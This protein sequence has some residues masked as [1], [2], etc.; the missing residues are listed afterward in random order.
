MFAYQQFIDLSRSTNSDDRGK[1]AHMAAL[2]F[3]AETGTT[4]EQAAVYAALLSFLDD[5]SVKVR[6]ALAYG[7]LR[8]KRAPRPVMLS[9]LQDAPII[10]RAVAQYCPVLV[11]ADLLGVART[12]EEAMLK[13][14]ALRDELSPRVAHELLMRDIKAISLNVLGRHDVLIGAETLVTIAE[15]SGG[16]PKMRGALL[17]REDLPA[18]VRL[19]LIERVRTVLSGARIVKGAIAGQR[20]TR[21]LRDAV[22]TAMTSIGEQE[23]VAGRDAYA[24]LLVDS[25]RINTRLMFH[26]IVNGHV[27]FFADMLALLAETPR[28]K[29]YTLLNGG[30]RAAL[31]AIFARCGLGEAVRNLLARLIYYARSSDLAGDYAAR[32][33]IVTALVEELLTEHEGIIPQSLEDVFAYLNEQNAILARHAARGVMPAFVEEVGAQHLMPLPGEPMMALPAA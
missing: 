9:L 27:L 10:A 33:F 6:A 30:S 31:N 18:T 5:A 15:N 1:A 19:Q 26:A 29:V 24:S 4:A 11:D 8:S 17:A 22:D 3:L 25:E 2:T 13:V 12:S 14:L 7:L 28:D 20:L 32:H 23:A 21:L 16:D